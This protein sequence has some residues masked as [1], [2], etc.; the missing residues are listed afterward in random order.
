MRNITCFVCGKNGH[1][2][3]DY[4]FRKS[5]DGVQPKKKPIN[6]IISETSTEGYGNPP[7]VF[8][9][10][11]STD[12]WVDTG[13]NVHVCYD[14]SLFSSYQA[15]GASSVLIGNESHVSVLGVAWW[16]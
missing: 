11:Q 4:H 15:A 2:A 6:V 14:I 8:S 13:A 3:K 1:M 12:W 9:A 10:C 7:V 5:E 16:I